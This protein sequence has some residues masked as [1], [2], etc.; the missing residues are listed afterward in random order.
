MLKVYRMNDLVREIG[1]SRSFIARMRKRGVFPEPINTGSR[2]LIWR[3]SDI[4]EWIGE[5]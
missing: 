2:S 1:F 4:R 5:E 3:V